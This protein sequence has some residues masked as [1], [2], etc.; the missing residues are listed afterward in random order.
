MF[1]KQ[2]YEE[3]AKIIKANSQTL[4]DIDVLDKSIERPEKEIC[5]DIVNDL[6]EYFTKNDSAFDAGLFKR[7]CGIT[8][9]TKIYSCQGK[10]PICNTAITL[11]HT[12]ESPDYMSDM[13]TYFFKCPVC[14]AS[15]SE[16]Y[17]VNTVY[18]ITEREVD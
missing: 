4:F 11:E 7:L 15:F 5:K 8:T 1:I 9:I 16:I 18:R 12:K 3:I 6:V 2:Y 13:H 10:C 14:G 17:D